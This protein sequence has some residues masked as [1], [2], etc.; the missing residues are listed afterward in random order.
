VFDTF[1]DTKPTNKPHSIKNNKALTVTS[2]FHLNQET[3]EVCHSLSKVSLA[4]SKLYDSQAYERFVLSLKINPNIPLE[5]LLLETI[6]LGY[7]EG[8]I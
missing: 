5:L 7:I 8:C 2:N 4:L 6:N 1:L 3:I